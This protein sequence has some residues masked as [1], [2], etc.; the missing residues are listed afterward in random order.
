[1]LAKFGVS[2]KCRKDIKLKKFKISFM[3]MFILIFTW[4]KSQ[5]YR[6]FV[7]HFD[8]IKLSKRSIDCLFYL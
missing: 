2:F 6:Y 3:I 8:Q 7:K 1:M 4:H 5:I